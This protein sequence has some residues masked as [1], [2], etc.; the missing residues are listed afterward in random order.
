[1]K[2]EKQETYPLDNS[3]MIHLAALQEGSSN[4]FRLSVC[5]KE[6]LMLHLE[7]VEEAEKEGKEPDSIGDS[8]VA[9]MG[10][11]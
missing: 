8:R 7:T 2:K 9:G 3:A 10:G 4:S 5:L 1:M 6:A 11:K